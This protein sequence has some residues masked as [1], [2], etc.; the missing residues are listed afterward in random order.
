MEIRSIGE[1]IDGEGGEGL[2]KFA[3]ESECEGLPGQARND[4]VISLEVDSLGL[5]FSRSEQILALIHNIVSILAE[6]LGTVYISVF[7]VA[8]TAAG[9]GVV[10]SVVSEFFGIL[11]KEVAVFIVSIHISIRHIFNVGATS[12]AG[13]VVGAGGSLTSFAFISRE[14]FTFARGAVADTSVCTLGIFVAVTILIRS[15]YPR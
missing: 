2:V 8:D 1:I 3:L 12:V 11:R 6:S 4:N 15:I 5:V 10:P 13:A 9:L 14:A 7:G